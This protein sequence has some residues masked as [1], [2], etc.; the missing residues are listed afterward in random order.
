MQSRTAEMETAETG[1]QGPRLR[2][3]TGVSHFC[4]CFQMPLVERHA[5][6]SGKMEGVVALECRSPSLPYS[7]EE[8]YEEGCQELASYFLPFVS[9]VL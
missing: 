5:E 7:Q 2:D 1:G 6:Q 4:F 9:V 3:L 8:D